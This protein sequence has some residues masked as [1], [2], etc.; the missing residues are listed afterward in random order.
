MIT[1]L[2][3]RPILTQTFMSEGKR[4][5]LNFQAQRHNLN[6]YVT[7]K[8]KNPSKAFPDDYDYLNWADDFDLFFVGRT[9]KAVEEM[10]LNGRRL[11]VGN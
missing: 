7:L 2:E 11:Y 10:R 8:S 1:D 5:E 3:D 4:C 6:F 9:Q